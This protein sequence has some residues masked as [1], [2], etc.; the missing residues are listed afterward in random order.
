MSEAETGKVFALASSAETAAKLLGSVT[1]TNIYGA[2]IDMWPGV[3]Y[4][5]AAIV[6]MILIIT[7]VIYL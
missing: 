4:M 7:M 1:F 3:A 5:W 2:S 6:Y